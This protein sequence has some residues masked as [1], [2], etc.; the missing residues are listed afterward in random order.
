[1]NLYEQW[2]Q[3]ADDLG[4]CVIENVPFESNAMGL[5]CGDCIGLNKNLE[6]IAEKACVLA[7]EVIHSQVNV[8]NILDQRIPENAKQE[9]KARKILHHHLV[10]LNTIIRLLKE[11]YKNMDEIAEKM[12]IT[13][14]LLTEAICGYKE[15][16]GISITIGDDV[17]FFEPT[18]F[19]KSQNID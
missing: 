19:L 12:G 7:E 15:E 5:V 6:T 10:D 9:R 18:V 1:M 16:Y 17:L 13:E 4:L 8:G 2:L 14:A 11:G 3:R